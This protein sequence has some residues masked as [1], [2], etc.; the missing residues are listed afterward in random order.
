VLT[1]RG[2]SRMISLNVSPPTG[3]QIQQ[4]DDG[5][6]P[7]LGCGLP[8]LFPLFLAFLSPF[9][10]PFRSLLRAALL[11][12]S[13]SLSRLSSL[14]VLFFAFCARSLRPTPPEPEQ[15]ACSGAVSNFILM[16]IAPH[17]AGAEAARGFQIVRP[18]G[19]A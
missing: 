6:R 10:S 7:S 3:R 18:A 12:L 11:S 2:L 15:S 17:A 9:L 4:F 14:R 13:E 19:R 1:T 8:R 16:T 5:L